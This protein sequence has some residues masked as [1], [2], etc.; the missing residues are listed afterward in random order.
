MQQAWHW[1]NE[2]LFIRLHIQPNAKKTE[3]AGIYNDRLKL[4]L[5]AP[6]VDG[7]A[8]EALAKFL[9]ESFKVKKSQIHLISG[10]LGRDKLIKIEPPISKMPLFILT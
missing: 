6:P 5:Q 3:W 4:R 7:K 2:T 10:E 1:Q 8:N 9:A